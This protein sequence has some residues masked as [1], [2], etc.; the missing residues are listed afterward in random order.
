MRVA[1]DHL[2]ATVP[3][4]LIDDSHRRS[5]HDQCAHSVMPEAVHAA[6]FQP[7]FSKEPMKV[8]VEN[9]AVHERRPAV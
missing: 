4:P 6:T 1:I 2:F 5:C 8:L 9:D 3:D 7:E